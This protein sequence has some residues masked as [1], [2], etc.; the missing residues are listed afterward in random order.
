M[1]EVCQKTTRGEPM[2][3]EQFEG[4][5]KQE[6]MQTAIA[7]I[8][9]S[10]AAR[11]IEDMDERIKQFGSDFSFLVGETSIRDLVRMTSLL[12]DINGFLVE[13]LAHSKDVEP[14]E[15]MQFLALKML[16]TEIQEED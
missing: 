1:L 2:S 6:L 10:V 5:T 13:S 14:E 7:V 3:D 4:A 11:S 16:E 9:S 8:A 12:A 15:M